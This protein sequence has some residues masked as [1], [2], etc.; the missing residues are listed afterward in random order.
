MVNLIEL[1][2]QAPTDEVGLNEIDARVWCLKNGYEYARAVKSSESGARFSYFAYE[3]C[4]KRV[5]ATNSIPP[6]RSYSRNRDAL[7]MLRTKGW[8]LQIIGLHDGRWRVDAIS[9]HG[10][11]DGK[12]FDSETLAELWTAVNIMEAS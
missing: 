5:R 10:C 2:E 12:L 8:T 7:R 1:I 3:M 11:I 9:K 6:A 4:G